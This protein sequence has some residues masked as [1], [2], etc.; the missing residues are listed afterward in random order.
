VDACVNFVHFRNV[1]CWG[2]F[3]CHRQFETNWI[4]L[5]IP[6]AKLKNF[7]VACKLL[8]LSQTD[9]S[10]KL[11]FKIANSLAPLCSILA[12]LLSCAGYLLIAFNVLNRLYVASV[13]TG[14]CLGVEALLHFAIISKLFGL[15]YYS[16]LFNLGLMAS[17]IGLYIF[18]QREGQWVFI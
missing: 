16:T 17:P 18:S 5:W 9:L 1:W 14:F 11:F 3:N 6:K 15:K 12:L 13:I 2:N 10:M 8:E 7:L 4:F